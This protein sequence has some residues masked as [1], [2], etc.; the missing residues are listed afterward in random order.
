MGKVF[1]PIRIVDPVRLSV[2]VRKENIV[3]GQQ[4]Y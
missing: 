1:F 2:G 4:G 3:V